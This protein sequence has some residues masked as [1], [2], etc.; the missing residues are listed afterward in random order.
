M[1]LLFIQEKQTNEFSLASKHLANLGHSV[2]TENSESKVDK[3]L[4]QIKKSEIIVVDDISNSFKIGYIISYAISEKKMII[5][6]NNESSKKGLDS[7]IKDLDSA[8]LLHATYSKN[9]IESVIEKLVDKA[10]KMM[11]TKFILIISPEIDRY[12]EWS[13]NNKRMHKAQIV[14]NAIEQDM[15]KDKSY[16]KYLESK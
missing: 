2:T 16:K 9:D 11:D 5:L 6:L 13:S 12:L 4:A 14:R 10:K 8:N 7:A 1:K 15:E 3:I